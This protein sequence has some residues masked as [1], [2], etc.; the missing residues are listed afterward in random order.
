MLKQGKEAWAQRSLLR[1]LVQRELSARHT[2]TVGGLFWVYAQPLLTVAVYYFVFDVVLGM[3]LGEDAPVKAVGTF[4]VVGLL[5]WQAFCESLSRTT[6]CLI[7]AAHLIQK[8]SLT[9]LIV[10]LRSTV[11]VAIV[12]MPLLFVLAL[13][14]IPLHGWSI[15]LFVLPILICTQ[16]VLVYLLGHVLAVFAAA[17]R[18][19]VQL[20]SF[21]LSIGVFLSPILFPV[22][23]FPSAWRWVLYA[24]PMTAWVQGYQSVLLQGAWP[25]IESFIAIAVWL[26]VATIM[27][28]LV[29]LHSRDQL[30][31]W[32]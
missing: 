11:A 8:S 6:I 10:V 7:E 29:D 20:V 17:L 14:Y 19:T 5:P 27:L 24:N 1:A 21:M 22:S 31:D 23:Q 28:R 13:L 25:T 9:P 30:V 18:D 15:A 2:G 16:F 3:R 12:Y 26:M 4:L 32:L